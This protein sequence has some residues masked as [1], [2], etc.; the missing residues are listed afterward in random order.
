MSKKFNQP[1]LLQ[2]GDRGWV[3]FQHFTISVE[4]SIVIGSVIWVDDWT[5]MIILGSISETFYFLSVYFPLN[6][7]GSSWLTV[8]WYVLASHHL[9]ASLSHWISTVLIV[10]MSATPTSPLEKLSTLTLAVGSSPKQFLKQNDD[11]TFSSWEE[12]WKSEEDSQFVSW[13]AISKVI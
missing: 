1:V 8:L 2:D 6:N 9:E 5:A 12:V 10:R 11:A 4:L 3:G 7:N 13:P